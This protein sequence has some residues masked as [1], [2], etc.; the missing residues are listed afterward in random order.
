[1]EKPFSIPSLSQILFH[2]AAKSVQEKLI[3]VYLRTLMI[4][5]AIFAP[6]YNNPGMESNIS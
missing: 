6:A 2:H 4:A 1:M 5:W 3:A